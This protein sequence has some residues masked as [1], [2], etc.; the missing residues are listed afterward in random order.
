MSS[1][2]S[3][4]L[5]AH[6]PVAVWANEKEIFCNSGAGYN[7]YAIDQNGQRRLLETQLGATKKP[8]PY[9]LNLGESFLIEPR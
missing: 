3:F 9:K 7:L 8:N 5:K 4:T 2:A 6:V 1:G